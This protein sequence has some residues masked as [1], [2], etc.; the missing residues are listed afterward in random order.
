M[1]APLPNRPTDAP[2]VVI[3]AHLTMCWKQL[4]PALLDVTKTISGISNNQFELSPPIPLTSTMEPADYLP[5]PLQL[6][7]P[8]PLLVL[9]SFPLKP[10]LV[11]VDAY[12]DFL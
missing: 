1:D 10:T 9:D 3:Q 4:P 11:Y 12:M 6:Y 5:V 8:E 2:I 7:D